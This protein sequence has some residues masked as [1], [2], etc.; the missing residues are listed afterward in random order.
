MGTNYIEYDK[1]VKA[2]TDGAPVTQLPAY[3]KITIETIIKKNVFKEGG[4][5]RFVNRIV[6]EATK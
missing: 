4:L 3:L 5:E 2:I 1:M 6:E